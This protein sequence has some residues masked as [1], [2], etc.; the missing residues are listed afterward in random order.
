[1]AAHI[2]HLLFAEESAELAGV[3][4]DREDPYFVLGA[5]GPD[6]FLH[7]QRRVPRAIQYGALL[8]RKGF[9]RLATVLSTD[10]SAE[11][12]RYAAGFITHIVL[13][14]VSHPFINYFAGWWDRSRPETRD[15]R[16]MHPFLERLID[17]E[18]LANREGRHP[19]DLDFA[20]H[21][22]LGEQMPTALHRSLVAAL[23]DSLDSAGRDGELEVRV[24]NA[25]QDALGYYRF[26][27]RA[28][29]EYMREGVRRETRGE[30]SD[31]WLALVHPPSLPYRLDVL[32]H[33]HRS[34]AHPCYGERQGEESFE[35]LWRHALPEAAQLLK[36]WSSLAESGDPEELQMSIGTRNLNDGVEG[37]R[38]CAKR[39]MDPLPLP[40]LYR[41][42][43]E[44][45]RTV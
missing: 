3:S 18:V 25:Y 38:P 13:D 26:T 1:M 2:A 8:H 11:V 31:R 10:R 23:R 32:N 42:I 6:L 33:D 15:Y 7:S 19:R 4:L 14:R 41:A 27:S 35:Q 22:D 39:L 20:A 16:H 45:Y 12:R 36:R 9:S 21:V 44:R 29:E 43:R 17:I 34:W 5:Q 30:I 40:E 24:A 37:A 28:D